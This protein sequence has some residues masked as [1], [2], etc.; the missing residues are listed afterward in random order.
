MPSKHRIA[1]LVALLFA[2][3]AGVAALEQAAPSAIVESVEVRADAQPE[4]PD[5]AAQPVAEGGEQVIGTAPDAGLVRATPSDT[6][7]QGSDVE[8]EIMPALA[9]YLEEMERKRGPLVAR[10]DVF[11]TGSDVEWEL[12][13]VQIAYFEQLEQQRMAGAQPDTQAA[14]PVS[15]AAPAGESR[16]PL[17]KAADY[18]SGLLKRDSAAAPADNTA[19]ADPVR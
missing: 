17:Q 19:A 6:F 1:I 7:P 13:P 8:W 12:L 3:P 14:A 11:P 18:I 9:R 16:N 2:V 4:S 10:G 5:A 15:A